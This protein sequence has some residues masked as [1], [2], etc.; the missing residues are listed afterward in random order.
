MTGASVRRITSLVIVSCCLAGPVRAQVLEAFDD[1]YG[2]PF[3]FTLEVEP[4]GVLENDI[5]DEENAGESGATAVLVS[6][7]S[8][9]TLTLSSDG[10]FTYSA[11]ASFAGTDSFVYRAEFGAASDEATVTL[12]ACDGGPEIYT[13]WDET[14]FNTL[15]QSLGYS[16][17]QEGFEDDAIWGHI[18]TPNSAMS[19][20]SHGVEWRSNHPDPPAMNPITT[21]TGP[22]HSGQW[23]VYDA[24]HGYATGSAPECDIDNPP[25]HC[26][27]HDGIS[28]TRVQGEDA[29]H[30]VGGWFDG[31][32]GAKMGIFIDG[33]GPYG[34]G[35][36]TFA[37]EFFGIVDTRPAGFTEF[38]FRELD[39][40]IGQAFYVWADD[41]S[42][43]GSF[44]TAAPQ[45]EATERILGIS[46]NPARGAA[47]IRFT[48]TGPARLRLEIYDLGGRLV[49]SLKD[50]YR[51]D[52]AYRSVWNLRD[53]AG[54]QV[55]SGVYFARLATS[56]GGMESVSSHKIVV[57]E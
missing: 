9:G 18:R 53:N 27:Y 34:G 26:L 44:P 38:E 33:V 43:V 29:L 4:F 46:P 49:R 23:G 17:A 31:I 56:Q 19:V 39:G 37:H 2:I 25:L 3:G 22:P 13:C 50:E 32:Y 15:V 54:R 41:F 8:H 16:T 55:A 51:G 12:S 28:G 52:G 36:L 48:L 1:L 35:H 40:K 7:V 24:N 21:S 6:D 30:G 42:L 20:I 10:S 47:D 45:S 5:L 11:G 14:A 57:I